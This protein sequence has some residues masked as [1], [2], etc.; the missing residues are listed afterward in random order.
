MTDQTE[1]ALVADMSML[2]GQYGRL[3]LCF[4]NIHFLHLRHS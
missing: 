3:I 4:C 1:K 2:N